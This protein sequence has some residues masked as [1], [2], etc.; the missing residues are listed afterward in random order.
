MTIAPDTLRF[1]L[2][3]IAQVMHTMDK[4][5]CLLSTPLPTPLGNTGV[6]LVGVMLSMKS[7]LQ[8]KCCSLLSSTF[9]HWYKNMVILKKETILFIL[10]TFREEAQVTDFGDSD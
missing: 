8:Y 9:N 4:S 6:V 3:K 7:V 5:G 10:L 2:R 1:S